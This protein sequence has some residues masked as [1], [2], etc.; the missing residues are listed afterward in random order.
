MSAS[1]PALPR[2]PKG[3]PSS[4]LV[5]FPPPHRVD[6]LGGS[7]EVHWEPA[8]A[9]TRHGLLAY[10]IDFLKTSNTWTEFVD[11]CPL[12]YSSPNAPLKAEVLATIVYSILTGQRRYS[13]ITA[14]SGDS[15]MA[16]LFGV[17]TFRSED[18]VRRAFEDADD[19]AITAWIDQQMDRT[20]SPLLEQEWVLDLDA[21]I[22]TLYGHQ[23]EARI[24]YNP[25]KPGRPS[26]VYQVMV[27]A[28][29]KL[30]LNVDAQAGNQ[31]A[32]E[33]AQPTLWGWLDARDRKL[34]PTL[35]RGDIAHANEKMMAGAEQRQLPYLFKLRQTQNVARTI[36]RLAR[37]KKAEWQNAGQGWEGV[38]T[39]LQLQGWT[40]QRR[41]IVLRRKLA[42]PPVKATGKGGAQACVPG[43]VVEQANGDWYEHAV[44]VTSWEQSDVRVLAQAYRDRADAENMFDELKNQ[45]GWTGYTTRDLKRSQ[46]MARLV[47]L[48]YNWWGIYTRIGTAD[49]HRE[50]I[51]T[52]P[53]LMEG[54]AE[55][56][57]H[58]RTVKLKMTSLHGRAQRIARLLSRIT[59]YLRSFLGDAEQLEPK[60]RWA[61]MLRQIF[62]RFC[63][64][65]PPLG[66]EISP[67]IAG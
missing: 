66:G 39:E 49:K 62:W 17:A 26:H 67:Q 31:S 47:A 35:I 46:L 24:G 3:E 57:E 21:T 33:H 27:L 20:F 16:G 25:T 37:N 4:S 34:W 22:K 8:P 10:F 7:V 52:R 32:S 61:V 14:L 38:E 64:G 19:D 48:T 59:S 11:S 6:T 15:V 23:E 55:Q 50:A 1:K 44:L 29:G 45:W 42:E 51:T 53:E 18:S 54:V 5:E 43:T 65:T 12:T 36:A 58:A 63:G 60:E 56:T 41:V 28:A 13:H 40:R 30:V 9:V 2:H